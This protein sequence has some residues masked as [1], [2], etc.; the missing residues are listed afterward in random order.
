MRKHLLLIFAL[1][2]MIAQGAWAQTNLGNVPETVSATD[3]T[4]MKLGHLTMTMEK[5]VVI[6][7]QTH[8]TDTLVTVKDVEW[9]TTPGTAKR[10]MDLRKATA[11]GFENQDSSWWLDMWWFTYNYPSVNAEGEDVT[12]SALACMPDDGCDY[13]NNVI[14]GCHVTITSNK[15]CPS[16]YTEEGSFKSDVS[17]LMN[18]AG[19]GL[20]FHS[21]QDD[22]P[23]YNLV[24]M[25]DYEGYGVTRS[26]AHP[27]LYQELTARQVVDGVRYGISLYN[28]DSSVSE[29]RH[30]FRDGW[31]SITVGYS[32]GGSVALATQRFIEQNGLTDELQLAGSVCG[33]GPYDLM[34]TLMYYV[35]QYKAG[36]K[37]NMPVVMPLILKG[38]CDSNPYMTDHQVSDYIKPQ[39]LETGILDWLN[40][41]NKTTDDITDAWKEQY[42]N[43]TTAD[44]DQGNGYGSDYFHAVLNDDG[45]STLG[46][47]MR[48][49]TLDYFSNLY[50]NYKDSYTSASGIPLP[51]HRGLMEDLHFA[52][53]SNNMT[54]G[55]QPQHPIF[56]YHSYDDTVVP[57]VNR[58]RAGNTIGDWVIKLHASGYL[59]Y[60]HVGSGRQFYL[61]LEEFNAIRA[62]AQAPVHPSTSDVSNIRTEYGSNSLDD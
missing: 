23:Y 18:H 9:N 7:P 19:S 31:R 47:M 8:L 55:W 25:P 46:K 60:D 13:V 38:M 56:M 29:I 28:S 62:L 34:S 37:L 58:E 5:E 16:R 1:L 30:P 3:A 2:C 21:V 48:S 12:L 27:Y 61:G 32:Q 4:I 41:K 39:F 40:E 54:M 42:K 45:T 44:Q 43:G 22:M 17:M 49:E 15:E 51:T 59:Q 10:R 36:K 33:D 24:I 6:D 11:T 53:E 26:H 14:I 52:L 35:G 20:V 57:E 50:D